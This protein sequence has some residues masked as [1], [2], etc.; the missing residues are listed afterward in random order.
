MVFGVII[1]VSVLCRLL[2]V[3]GL[4]RFVK[5]RCL[6]RVYSLFAE[7]FFGF[8]I[9]DL[10]K[11][12]KLSTFVYLIFIIIAQCAFVKQKRHNVL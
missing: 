10:K 9:I 5:L 12:Q 1:H 8:H 6:L 3:C 4:P 7:F 2:L 11:R